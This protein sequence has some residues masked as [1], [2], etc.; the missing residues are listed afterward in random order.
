MKKAMFIKKIKIGAGDALLY[1]LSDPIKLGDNSVL[2]VVVSATT[3]PIGG[4]RATVFPANN[5]G[6]IVSF[7]SIGE[8]K[9]TLDHE[10]PLINLGYEIW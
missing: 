5:N 2:D 3:S 10:I 8:A 9:G 1:K 7:E 4:P 6:D